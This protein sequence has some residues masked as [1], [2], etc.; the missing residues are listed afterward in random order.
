MKRYIHIFAAIL[1]ALAP[2]TVMQAQ[3]PTAPTED[4]AALAAAVGSAR[5]TAS[6]RHASLSVCVY[7]ITRNTPVYSYDPQ[8]SLLP[9]SVS[10]IF[11][12]AIG[13]DMLSSK[14]R[15]KTTLSY[16]GTIDCYLDT[17]AFGW[18]NN[19]LPVYRAAFPAG[20][21]LYD[22]VS[23]TVRDNAMAL[24]FKTYNNQNMP[25]ETALYKADGRISP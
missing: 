2:A 4:T 25:E 20:V 7:N 9:A 14:F 1:I 16:S 12:V 18:N 17:K 19:V 10:K 15:F 8:R 21:K 5:A 6:M 11:P 3:E 24:E 22:P 23:K 13:F